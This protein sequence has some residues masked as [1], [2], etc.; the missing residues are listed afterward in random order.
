MGDHFG[1]HPHSTAYSLSGNIKGCHV[2]LHP[3]V[4][5]YVKYLCRTTRTKCPDGLGLVLCFPTLSSQFL[6]DKRKL[7]SWNAT[8][9]YLYAWLSISL[10]TDWTWS[11]PYNIALLSY[12]I[13]E[14]RVWS[15]LYWLIMYDVPIW[16]DPKSKHIGSWWAILFRNVFILSSSLKM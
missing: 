6:P 14:N 11:N 3:L 4:C 13:Q 9:A 10:H 15:L 12:P 5:S 1:P 16:A 7:R 2:S 8:P